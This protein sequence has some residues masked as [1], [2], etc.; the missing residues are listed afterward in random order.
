VTYGRDE[1]LAQVDRLPKLIQLGQRRRQ[2][3]FE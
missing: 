2:L 1:S 3:G